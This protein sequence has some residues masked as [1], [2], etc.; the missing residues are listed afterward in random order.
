ML[1]HPVNDNRLKAGSAAVLILAKQPALN[2]NFDL[3]PDANPKSRTSGLVRWQINPDKDWG[4]KPRAARA[5]N[6]DDSLEDRRAKGQQ[7]AE[8]VR[9]R[10]KVGARKFVVCIQF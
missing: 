9:K 6:A 8:M 3:H 4:P 2:A 5:G 10:R 1:S 7:R